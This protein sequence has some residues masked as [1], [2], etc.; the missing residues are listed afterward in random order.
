MVMLICLALANFAVS[1]PAWAVSAE[2]LL[3]LMVNE[4]VITPEKAERIKQKAS[5]IDRA[6][7]AEEDAKRARELEAVKQEAKSEAKAEAKAEAAKEAKE[8]VKAAAPKP[9]WKAFW[10]NGLKVESTDGK[11]K[12]KVGG[13]IQYDIA[14]IASP[15]RRFVDQVSAGGTRSNHLTGTGSEFRRARLYIEGTA[16]K[17]VEFKAQYD[18]ANAGN[19]TVGF[20]DVWVGLKDL[21]YIGHLR[22]GQMKEPFSLEELTSSNFNTFMERALPNAFSPA[23]NI[24]GMAFNT[25]FDK[26]LW[27][28]VGAFVNDRDDFGD[29]YQNWQEW[30]TTA[31]LAGTPLY[32]DK[33][34][35]LIHLG[36]SYSHQFRNDN[37]NAFTLRYR[38]RPES[39]ITD[40]RTVDTAGALPQIETN[41][42]N[43]I[44]PEFALVWGPVSIQSEYMLSV[45]GAS[46]S[47]AIPTR[48]LFLTGSN[49]TFQGAY[50]YISYFLTGEHRNY[51]QSNACFDRVKPKH[52]FDLK[53]GWGA[54]EVAFR[55]SYLNLN[56]KG[57]FGGIENDYTAGLNWY[58]TPNAR[59]MFNYV[60]GEIG[61]RQVAPRLPAYPQ[62]MVKGAVDVVQTRF[63]VDF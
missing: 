26:R 5:K 18:F 32:E 42:V 7:K 31:R 6:K 52:N 25:A 55:W 43:L 44:N 13:R 22:F 35:R 4:K 59:W 24:G 50:A 3:D 1:T 61:H 27:W 36:F 33:G 45:A 11:N 39:H 16:Y 57:I 20:R 53:G 37:P 2:E 8:V 28:G 62:N 15:T 48:N 17:I 40:V 23:R 14:N 47:R 49:P 9:E 63:Q 60:Y 58:L 34:K 21:P 12:V 54:W 46:R 10:D 56:S 38:E 19:G 51:N 29:S 41:G 30:E